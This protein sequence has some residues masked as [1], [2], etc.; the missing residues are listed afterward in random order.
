MDWKS[1]VQ[2]RI[3]GVPVLYIAAAF[4]VILAVVAW[5]MK[6]T[7]EVTGDEATTPENVPESA[8]DPAGADY[9]GLA[10]QGTVTV[11]QGGTTAD[12]ESEKET[13]DDWERAAVSYLIEAK[14]ATAG[15]AQTAINKYL[16]GADLS[17]DEG[18]LRDAA[19]TKLGLPPEKLTTVGQVGLAPA[20][21]QF[22]NFPGKHTVKN[23][24]DNTAAKLAQLYYGNGDQAHALKIVAANSSLGPNGTTYSVGASVNIPRWENPRFYTITKTTQW[25]SQVAAKN[26]MTVESFTFLNP[27]LV[28]PYK[29]GSK[30]RVG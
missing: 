12:E 28:A 19:V 26:G 2:K 3:G 22:S 6:P 25:P 5:K 4:V 14:L 17:Y 24:N 30:V 7:E 1:L 23:V 21:K 15:A 20:Q 29:V 10:T 16:E 9:S 8:D 18:A 27:G 13:N 11:V